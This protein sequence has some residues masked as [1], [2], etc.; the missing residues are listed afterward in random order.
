MIRIFS[1]KRHLN[2]QA[3]CHN[4]LARF[5]GHRCFN[6]SSPSKGTD[7][8]V[9]VASTT[10]TTT[11]STRHSTVWERGAVA[12]KNTTNSGSNHGAENRY[13]ETIRA[14]HDPALHLKTVEDELK[15]TIGRALG[16]QGDKIL[17][18]LQQMDVE[19]QRYQ[20]LMAQQQ[21]TMKNKSSRVKITTTAGASHDNNHP[22]LLATVARY[23]E[24]RQ[25]ALTAR[26]ELIVHRQAV[27]FIVNNH[28]YVTEQY[29]IPDAITIPTASSSTTDET[30]APKGEKMFSKNQLDWW[31]REG[32][33]K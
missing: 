26:W 24:H 2:R 15:G 9:T 17:R 14:T 8:L 30:S 29:P 6:S 23:N 16:K 22:D 21:H 12:V 13:L 1:N 28:S 11:S 27:G 19:L 3:I 31:Q 7:D 32:R 25:A 18:A 33:W 10:T 20:E 4:G 5:S